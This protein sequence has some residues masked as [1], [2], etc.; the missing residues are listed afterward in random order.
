MTLELEMRGITKRFPGIL[1]NDRVNFELR[2]GEIH[3]LLGENGAGKTTLMNILYGLIRPDEGE[4]LIKG[5][6]VKISSPL[7]ALPKGVGMVHQHFM[8]VPTMTVVE[9]VVIGH[10]P[11]RGPLLQLEKAA[12]R[13][14]QLSAE[15]GL[16]VEPDRPTWQ[17]SIG[18]QQRVE[19]LKVLYRGA[20]ILILDE[21]TA[22]LTPPEVEGLFKILR[23]MVDNGKSIIFITHKLNEV[24]TIS[25]RV[26]VMRRGSV[27]GTWETPKIDQ[28]TLA[29]LLVGRAVTFAAHRHPAYT[30]E[31]VASLQRIWVSGPHNKPAVVDFSLDLRAGE[32]VGIA[33]VDGN[34]Q[35][36]LAEAIT[37][38]KPL[39]RGTLILQGTDLSQ[40]PVWE[41]IAAGIMHI[42]ADRKK[43]GLALDLSLVQNAAMKNHRSPPYSLHGILQHR[44]IRTFA[45]GLVKDYDI[46]SRSI[47]G[48]AGTL[49]G[50]NL[51]KLLLARKTAEKPVL[52][53][54]EQPTRGLDIGASE[55]VKHLLQDKRD[56]GTAVLLISADLDEV[57]ELADRIVVMY[58]GGIQYAFRHED[59]DREKIGLAMAGVAVT[60]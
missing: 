48:I 15:F 13:I 43:R 29:N 39:Q 20:E 10:E 42:P 35:S 11:T 53:I 23:A 4:I 1:A 19:I 57:L 34:G 33:G 6:A 7:D 21:P 56:E 28:R 27:Q 5:K 51:Q 12:R 16:G 8:L 2:Q 49:S 22:V 60:A 14:R 45:A 25:D 44:T 41:R 52:L 32:I 3:A 59:I 38:L 30:G 55:F 17:L 18:E 58:E 24:M 40:A 31:V 54:A 46:R 26:T 9:N 50:G 37:G 36:E 47:D